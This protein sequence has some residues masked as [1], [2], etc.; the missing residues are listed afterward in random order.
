MT[1]RVLVTGAGGKTGRA[2]IAALRRRGVPVRAFV[3][4]RDRHGDLASH[5]DV[6]VVAGDQRDADDLVGALD[7]CAAVYAIAP[8]VTP[9]EVAMGEAIIAAGRAAGRTRVIYHSVLDPFEPAMPHHADKGRVEDLLRSSGLPA[10]ILRPN[11]YLQNLDAYLQDIQVGSY[12]VPYDVTRGLSMVDLREVAEVAARALTGDLPVGTGRSIAAHELSGPQPVRPMDVAE[13]AA[14]ILERPVVAERQDP[15]DWA[16][17][18]AHLPSD[19]RNR[20]HAM[21]RHYDRF[22]FP[23]DPAPLDRLLGRSPTGLR[24]YLEE[25]LL[26]RS[27]A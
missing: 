14:S 12:R 10:T 16:V 26:G 9:G 24:S 21:F 6:E 17:A 13:V 27:T 20:L 19:A 22:G 5:A 15:D 2:V 4:D 1:T 25:A 18:N 8:N 11:A 23:G 3:R 7:G